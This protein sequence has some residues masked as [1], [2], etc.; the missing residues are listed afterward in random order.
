MTSAA[1]EADS[2]EQLRDLDP[3]P[4]PSPRLPDTDDD[5]AALSAA[6]GVFHRPEEVEDYG[7]LHSAVDNDK[8]YSKDGEE[9]SAGL[10]IEEKKDEE[11]IIRNGKKN[12]VLED[13]VSMS[14]A[15]S[16]TVGC[17]VPLAVA[18]NETGAEDTWKR[19]P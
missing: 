4:R 16:E 10:M 11:K 15:T 17:L 6:L 14:I 9:P 1:L 18:M 2:D 12:G 8:L 19:S 3:T 5:V 7:A 13:A